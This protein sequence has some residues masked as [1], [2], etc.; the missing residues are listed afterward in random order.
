MTLPTPHFRV[1]HVID[2]LGLSGGAEQQLASNLHRFSDPRLEHYVLC[3]YAAPGKTRSP[4][5]PADVPIAFLLPQGRRTRNRLSLIAR[6]YLCTRGVCKPRAGGTG[7]L[8][9]G[10]L[11]LWAVTGREHNLLQLC[12][13]QPTGETQS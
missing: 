4:E 7:P 2:S 11:P 10:A 6:L 8:G 13:P 12:V 5:I 9:A 1:L 3:L